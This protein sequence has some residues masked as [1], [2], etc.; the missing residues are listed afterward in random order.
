MHAQNLA[1]GRSY[2]GTISI[3]GIAVEVSTNRGIGS[4]ALAAKSKLV[5]AKLPFTVPVPT[6][7][8]CSMELAVKEA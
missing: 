6:W 3:I 5:G 4:L 2:F 1:K 8:R 7:G